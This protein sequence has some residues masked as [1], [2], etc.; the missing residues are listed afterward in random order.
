MYVGGLTI[1]GLRNLKDFA[2]QGGTLIFLD[3]S[4]GL[5][6]EHFQIPVKNALSGVARNDFVCTGS[7]LRMEFNNEHPLCYGMPE[8][9]AGIFGSR[10]ALVRL[11][12]FAKGKEPISAARYP[13]DSLLLSGWVH[14]DR[15]IRQK[16]TVL[17]VPYG[18]G[19]LVLLGFP[20]QYRAQPYGTFKILFNAVFYGGLS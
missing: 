10:T 13:N 19:R 11:P 12:S 4:C 7:V 8:E 5:A 14:G 1:A 17:D 18:K 20:V 2:D 6:I 15:L 16:S 3:G 9:G